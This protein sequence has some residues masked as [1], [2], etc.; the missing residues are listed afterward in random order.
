[1]SRL[2]APN[3]PSYHLINDNE[4]IASESD[5]SDQQVPLIGTAPP[6][7]KYRIVYFI[8][9]LQGVAMLLGWNVFIT[10]SVFFHSRFLGSPYSDDFQNYFSIVYELASLIFLVHALYTQTKENASIRLIYSLIVT[11]LALFAMTMSIQF[12]DLFTSSGY[13]Y[14]T[15][16]LVCLVGMTI[17]YQQNSIFGIA[18]LFPPKYTQ[19]V[20][21]GQGLAGIAVSVSQIFSAVAVNRSSNKIDKLPNDD[22]L[23]QSI[24]NNLNNRSFKNTFNKIHKLIFSVTFVFSVTLSIYPSVTAFIKSVTPDDKKNIFLPLYETLVIT[25]QNR[26]T[27]LSIIRVIFLPLILICNVDVGLSNM[28]ILPLLIDSDLVYFLILFLFAISN[29][30]V[31]SLSMMAGPQVEGVEK[32]LAGTLLSFFLVVGLVVGSILSFPLRAI[33]CGCNPL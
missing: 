33:S 27:L 11:A 4:Y 13:F 9:F 2:L 5:I 17:S 7:D 20:M 24:D 29:G 8:F 26:I 19:A 28:R 32:E 12:L 14:F 6:K 22:D 30:Y 1:M 16:T 18:A 23:T 10:A 21:S 25:D 3:E 15:I 31:V